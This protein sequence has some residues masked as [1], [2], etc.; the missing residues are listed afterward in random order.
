MDQ[1]A[2]IER[3]SSRGSS[4]SIFNVGPDRILPAET[5]FTSDPEEPVLLRVEGDGGGGGNGVGI[6]W[7]PLSLPTVVRK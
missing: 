3:M 4:D 6:E 5:H 1:N 7:S 2:V